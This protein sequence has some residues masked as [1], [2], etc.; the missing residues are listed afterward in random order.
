MERNERGNDKGSGREVIG[1]RRENRRGKQRQAEASERLGRG[2]NE[3]RDS[4]WH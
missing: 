4:V 1:K 3:Q 2:H